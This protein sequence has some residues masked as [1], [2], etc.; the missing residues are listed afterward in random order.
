MQFIIIVFSEAA[1]AMVN[2]TMINRVLN[3]LDEGPNTDQ[4]NQ[5]IDQTRP[6]LDNQ[7]HESTT[8]PIHAE[9]VW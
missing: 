8:P 1:M 5:H 3:S 9:V 6:T 2:L 7:V 4:Q